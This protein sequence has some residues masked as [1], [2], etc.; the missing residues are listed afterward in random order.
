MNTVRDVCAGNEERDGSL[1]ELPAIPDLATLSPETSPSSMHLLGLS[2][3][4]HG[5]LMDESLP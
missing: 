1:A 5:R 4:E 2:E 3:E